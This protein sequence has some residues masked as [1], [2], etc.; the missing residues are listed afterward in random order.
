MESYGEIGRVPVNLIYMVR[1]CTLLSKSIFMEQE[2]SKAVQ[3]RLSVYLTDLI[4]LNTASDSGLQ[5]Y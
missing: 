5:L 1:I 4:F 2:T 3:L